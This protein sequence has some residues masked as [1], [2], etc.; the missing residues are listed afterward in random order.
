MSIRRA[1]EERNSEW[2]G[3]SCAPQIDAG[4]SAAALRDAESGGG[5]AAAREPTGQEMDIHRA[6]R[7]ASEVIC[8][9]YKTSRPVV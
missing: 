5:R 9:A 4:R 1:S 3:S 7:G 6:H 2:P 8:G